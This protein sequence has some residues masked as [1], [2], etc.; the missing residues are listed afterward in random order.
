AGAAKCGHKLETIIKAEEGDCQHRD[1][2]DEGVTA[3]EKVCDDKRQNCR[4]EMAARSFEKEIWERNNKHCTTNTTPESGA[5]EEHQYAKKRGN[6]I[7]HVTAGRDQKSSCR[8]CHCT[9]PP[10]RHARA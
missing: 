3:I 9:T 4:K 8:S 2:Y 1:L 7:E 6:C 10:H 5:L